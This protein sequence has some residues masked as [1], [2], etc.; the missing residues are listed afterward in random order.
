MIENEKNYKSL[1]ITQDEK[2]AFIT[3][4]ERKH[5]FLSIFISEG[6]SLEEKIIR[7]TRNIDINKNSVEEA[8]NTLRKLFSVFIKYSMKNNISEIDSAYIAIDKSEM[9]DQGKIFFSTENKLNAE[10]YY[11]RG[12]DS[13]AIVS[14]ILD[15]DVMFIR[16]RDLKPDLEEEAKKEILIGPF[17]RLTKLNEISD[18]QD[19]TYYTGN[20]EA[21]TLEETVEYNI[22]DL[23][24]RSNEMY[25][26]LNTFVDSEEEYKNLNLRRDMVTTRM[27][28]RSL[29][30]KGK[31]EISEE[32]DNLTKQMEQVQ[33]KGLRSKE[34][35]LNW[36]AKIVKYLMTENEKIKEEIKSNIEKEEKKKEESKR[37]ELESSKLEILKNAKNTALKISEA[38][39]EKCA[40]I[41][42]KLI[43]LK[44][45]QEVFAKFTLKTGVDYKEYSK[46][47]ETIESVN[48]LMD[49]I[50]KIKT[51]IKA[52]PEE[53][54]EENEYLS[55]ISKLTILEKIG[56][57]INQK[58][59]TIIDI[60]MR[61]LDAIEIST[62]KK[63]IYLK[64]EENKS[65]VNLSKVENERERLLN[66]SMF[67]KII[68]QFTGRAEV[69]RITLEQ[70]DIKEKSIKEKLNYIKA[71][72][73]A[74]YSIHHMMAQLEIFLEENKDDDN[75]IKEYENMQQI[76]KS[77]L[78]IFKV[79][80]EKVEKEKENILGSSL[81]VALKTKKGM[82]REEKVIASAVSWLNKY[83]YINSNHQSEDISKVTSKDALIKE[84]NQMVA[85]LDL[86]LHKSNN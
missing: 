66:R 32:I 37:N 18:I 70:L 45:K 61:N 24:K 26:H 3:F 33:Q 25:L 50:V 16:T 8:L 22:E 73:R 56:S 34:E 72:F 74:S 30:K 68:D 41:Q 12:I 4:R 69:N 40:T 79:E 28:D 20:I 55:N 23:V 2:D 35:Y 39:E 31:K 6:S 54:K 48:I 5:C 9:N 83:G 80:K 65:V 57:D 51:S 78:E 47:E 67:L 27:S 38:N 29:D 13:K 60:N 82:S 17:T 64:I 86:K 81:P 43:K 53:Y 14:V 44:Q 85:E 36:K 75:Y 46:S 84:T 63:S 19:I 21:N 71:E 62:L 58:L 11:A 52:I 77:I 59:N 10:E 7:N 49:R 42:S 76:K 1:N 15:K